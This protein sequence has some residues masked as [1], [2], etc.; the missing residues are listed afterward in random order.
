M[1]THWEL[2]ENAL[3]NK[4]HQSLDPNSNQAWPPPPHPT[5]VLQKTLLFPHWAKAKQIKA[6]WGRLFVVPREEYQL[7]NSMA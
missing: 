7:I 3:R 6:N 2:D 4:G 5:K 1:G